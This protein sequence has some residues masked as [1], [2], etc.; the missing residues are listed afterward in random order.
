MSNCS[1]G[2]VMLALSTFRK[3]DK[4]IFAAIREA[5]KTKKLLVVFVADVNLSRY[6]VGAEYGLSPRVRD[7]CESNLLELHEKQG[8]EL[9]DEIAA[10]ADLEGIE[11]E[12]F[13]RVGRFAPTCLD[14]IRREKP[15]MVVTTRSHRPDWVKKV[16]GHPVD[17][18]VANAGCPVLIF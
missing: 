18:L 6:F 3:S 11:M 5:R 7:R 8:R 2:S 10:K 1:Q 17:D 9:V 14:V 12:S 4:A 13:V 15:S 16:F